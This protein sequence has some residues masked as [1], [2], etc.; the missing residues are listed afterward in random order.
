M[1]VEICEVVA[2]PVSEVVIDELNDT[3]NTSELN[4]EVKERIV[5]LSLIECQRI[6]IINEGLI[7]KARRLLLLVTLSLVIF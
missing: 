6:N 5:L 4:G 7:D 1:V 2:L 3:D